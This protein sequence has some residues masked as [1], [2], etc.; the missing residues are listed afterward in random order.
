MPRPC[1]EPGF[2]RIAAGP[3]FAEMKAMNTR[4]IPYPTSHVV[5]TIADAKRADAAVEALV[6]AGFERPSLAVLH[7]EDG[8]RRLDPTGA[9]H[10]VLERLQRALIRIGARAEEYRHLMRHV[11]DVR[12]GRRVVM[13]PAPKTEA[14][15]VA[16]DILNA[17]GAESV[18]FYGRWA[19]HGLAADGR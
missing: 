10:G 8:L 2:P 5:G 6:G 9:Q 4:F 1:R 14:R 16:A 7:G 12:A 3:E 15:A 11:D 13:V 18:G 19:W 17:Y